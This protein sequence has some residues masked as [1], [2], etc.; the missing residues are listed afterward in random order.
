MNINGKICNEIHWEKELLKILGGLRN[1]FIYGF[2]V[3]FM[4][5]IV[6]SLLFSKSSVAKDF[7]RVL[8]LSL[9][10]GGRLSSFVVIYKFLLLVAKKV[11][12]KERDYHAFLAGII[13]GYIIF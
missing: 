11:D 8:F 9:K 6:M 7:K 13:G 1:G 2:K 12:K 3:R 4:H 5:T 10:H